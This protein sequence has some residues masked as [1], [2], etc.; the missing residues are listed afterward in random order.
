VRDGVNGRLVEGPDRIA[1]LA[2]GL[3]QMMASPD[4][5]RRLGAAGPASIENFAP[6]R[7]ADVWL[8]LLSRVAAHR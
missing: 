7:I 6:E 4:E 1:A 8:D 3:A 2:V 5:R